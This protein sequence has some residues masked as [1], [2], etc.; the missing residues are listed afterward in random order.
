MIV[1]DASAA[2]AWLF[3]EDVAPEVEALFE[4]LPRRRI[5]VPSLWHLE[6]ANVLVI[7]ERKGRISA[8]ELA[9]FKHDLSRLP[10][11][12][13]ALDTDMVLQDILPLAREE[14]LTV[15]DATYLHLA[16]RLRIPLATLDTAL[17][18]A[19]RNRAVT[20]LPERP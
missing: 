6:V 10:I 3:G 13:E 16:A 19:A 1:L 4:A 20:I 17:R 5:I 7:A 14:N 9:R 8:G 15:Y 11:V 2:L 18:E 12:T